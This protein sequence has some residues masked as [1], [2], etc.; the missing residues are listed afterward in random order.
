VIAAG[1]HYVDQD[2]ANL[3][4]NMSS[5]AMSSVGG[6]QPHDNMMPYLA[7]NFIIALFGVFPQQN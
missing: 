4:G 1:K 6:S 2:K 7:I 5:S 3:T